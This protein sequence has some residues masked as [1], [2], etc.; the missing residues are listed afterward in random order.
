MN[1]FS[2]TNKRFGGLAGPTLI[3]TTLLLAACASSP[4]APSGAQEV[5]AKFTA[6]Q[7]NPDIANN[8]RAELNEAHEAVRL[9]EE[10]L[11]GKESELG[12]YRVY[13]ADNKIEM[14]RAKARTR[15]AETQ[16]T[17]MNAE[18]EAQRLAAQRLEAD[19]A[20]EERNASTASQRSQQRQITA[21]G[22]RTTDR[23][24]EPGAVLF[25][26]AS[27]DVTGD[28]SSN[29]DRMVTFLN[30]NPSRRVLIEGHT[31]NVGSAAFN[32]GLSQRRADSVRI[33][34]SDH[35]IR[36]SRLDV[37]GFGLD[38]PVANNTSDAGRQQNRR[39]QV[40]IAKQ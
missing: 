15:M 12:E 35:G 24:L 25:A 3:L 33:Y 38:R 30:A 32:Q 19:R 27:S 28:G 7:N 26:F 6:M 4:V 18:R 31:D 2:F 36:R 37:S 29:L 40:I 23:G 9:A 17:H 20:R 22:A 11:T 39:V 13:M 14:A 16:L 21:M 34:L 10:P 1:T 5:R 8:A